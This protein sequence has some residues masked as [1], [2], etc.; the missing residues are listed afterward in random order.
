MLIFV[1][2]DTWEDFLE[3]NGFMK[4]YHIF[5]GIGNLFPRWIGAT[6]ENEVLF[7]SNEQFDEARTEIFHTITREFLKC[8]KH[9]PIYTWA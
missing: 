3:R 8:N 5:P 6:E 7:T 9:T 1:G 4:I 2:I